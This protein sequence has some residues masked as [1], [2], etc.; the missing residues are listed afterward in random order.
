MGSGGAVGGEAAEGV[1]GAGAAESGDGKIEKNED[2]QD[3]EKE[4]VDEGGQDKNPVTP[5]GNKSSKCAPM[6][7]AS[8]YAIMIR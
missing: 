1:G 6:N 5:I 7:P 2:G 4:V 8:R 3:R